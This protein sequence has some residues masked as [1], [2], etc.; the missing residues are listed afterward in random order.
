MGLVVKE[1]DRFK[2]VDEGSGP[3]LLLLDGVCGALSNWGGVVERCSTT[4]RVVNPM[5]PIYVM[6][7]KDAGL[8]GL[9][10]FLEDFVSCMDLRDVVLM[11]NS[12]GGHIALMYTLRNG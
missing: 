12:L 6:P 5:L 8:D 1:S 9:T 3:V 4:F 10:T 2:F 7:I 11:G